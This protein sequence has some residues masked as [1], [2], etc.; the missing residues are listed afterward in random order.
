[1]KYENSI[2]KNDCEQSTINLSL[3]LDM[4]ED[5]HLVQHVIGFQPYHKQ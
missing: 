2:I 4:V 1:M 5:T 3:A